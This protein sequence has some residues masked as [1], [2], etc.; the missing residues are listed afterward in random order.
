MAIVS[1]ATQAGA[2]LHEGKR[3]KEPVRAASTAT[4]TIATPGAS[5]DGVTLVNGDRVLLKDQS[6]A[7]QNGIYTWAG[8]AVALVRTADADAAADFHHGFAVYVREGTTN[9]ARFY[10]FTQSA[11]ITLGTTALT[12]AVLPTGATL[13]DP[14]TTRGDLLRRDASA[15][16]RLALGTAG[17]FLGSDGTDPLWTNSAQHFSASG[18]TGAVATSRYVGATVGGAPVTGT[19]AV[20]DFIIDQGGK[21]WICTSAGSPGTWAQSAGGMSN[22]MTTN[23]DIIVGGSAGV[24]ARL[25][26]G[27][28]GQVL[29]VSAGAVTWQNSASGFS[30]PMTQPGDMIY[31][32]TA[33]AASRLAVGA[34]GQV[35]KVVGGLPGWGNE[36]G[37]VS[38][39]TE[40]AALFLSR[41]FR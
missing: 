37:G 41:H 27:A 14:T 32:T 3:L 4:L 36:A 8:A 33:G 34:N 31:G 18:L 28:N 20:G 21:V 16:A 5:I 1:H 2:S 38:S 9:A 25:G 17:Q 15:L 23:Q 10:V 13:T 12:F 7:S 39:N 11:V 26:V 19:F 40:A 24:P 35:L 30:N 6:T 29:S 22:P